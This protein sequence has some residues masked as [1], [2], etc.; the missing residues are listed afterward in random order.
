MLFNSLHFLVFLPIVLCGYYIIPKK[1][2]Y[3]WLL[4]ASYYFYMCW[5]AKYAVLIFFST[6]STYLIALFIEK[7]KNII[8][9]KLCLILGLTI[10]LLILFVFKYF[11]FVS[12]TM[13]HAFRLLNIN[14][15]TPHIDVLLPVGIS[16]YTFQALSYIIDVYRG[17]GDREKLFSL[18][19]FC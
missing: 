5:N 18:C 10:N 19:A 11:N 7:Y 17:G 1:I 12:D 2:R 14:I 13:E 6:I 9:K 3:I 8:A 15:A 4:G 16:F